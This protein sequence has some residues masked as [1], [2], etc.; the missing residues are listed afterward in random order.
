MVRVVAVVLAVLL[1]VARLL[2]DPSPPAALFALA[3]AAAA[4]VAWRAPLPGLVLVAALAALP[5]GPVVLL[6]WAAFHAGHHARTRRD[7]VLAGAAAAVHAAGQAFTVPAQILPRL[8][9]LV[10]LPLLVGHHLA[11][12][13]RLVEALTESNRR[14]RAAHDLLAARERLRIARDVH[15]SLGHQLSLL[16]LRAAALETRT[17]EAR[18][19]AVTARRAVDQLHDLVGSLRAPDAPSPTL[20]DLDALTA[21]AGAAG[22]TLAVRHAGDRRDLDPQASRAAYRVVEEGLTNVAK[23]AP[24]AP[25]TVTFD[26]EPD[27]L[28]ITV[29]NPAGAPGA[30]EGHGLTGLRERLAEAGGTLHVAAGDEFRLAAMLPYPAPEPDPARSR[31]L[32]TALAV[33]ALVLALLPAT[34]VR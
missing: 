21:R 1:D 19:L 26:W 3:A 33:G 13:R 28:L 34:G 8:L 16:T 25:V 4:A 30:P 12:H 17:P 5:D 32:T 11:R 23:H 7:A 22:L 9:M 24:G 14:L 29:A 18:D 27:A 31:A 20:A 10:A 2:S 6:V 15:D